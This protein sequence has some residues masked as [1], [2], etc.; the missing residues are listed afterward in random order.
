[1]IR[2][3]SKKARAIFQFN[4]CRARLIAEVKSH[5]HEHEKTIL[6]SY[7]SRFVPILGVDLNLPV[8][9]VD[10]HFWKP[11]GCVETFLDES[12]RIGVFNRHLAK[13]P[14][15]KAPLHKVFFP[16]QHGSSA[17]SHVDS[18]ITPAASMRSKW[19][20]PSPPLQTRPGL[21]H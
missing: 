6:L 4:R 20:S 19:H 7:E 9:G 14:I 15:I 10:I 12:R 1:M 17:Q 21:S 13:A 18:C 5:C 2:T 16:N 11:E 8:C 3:S